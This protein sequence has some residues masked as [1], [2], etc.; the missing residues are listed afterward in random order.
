MLSRQGRRIINRY[1]SQALPCVLLPLAVANAQA[2]DCSSFPNA[3]KW[4]FGTL[5]VA[6]Q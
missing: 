2:V 3:S 4:D 1:L 5:E 6:T